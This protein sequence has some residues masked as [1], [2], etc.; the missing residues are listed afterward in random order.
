M[1]FH[2]KRI[3]EEKNISIE[4][5]SK[6][7]KVAKNSVIRIEAGTANPTM[8]T[9][10]KLAKALDVKITQAV[11]PLTEQNPADDISRDA[12]ISMAIR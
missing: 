11:C 5:L 1:K 6:I 9:M 12:V 8:L 10:C 3:R 2:L 4:R 7:A